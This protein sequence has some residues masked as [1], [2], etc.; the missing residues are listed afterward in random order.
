VKFNDLK[1]SGP[2]K[3]G[4]AILILL[5]C[6]VSFLLQAQEIEIERFEHIDTR[7]GLS[8]NQVL[9]IYCDRSGYLWF[10]TFNGLN[11]Y[12]GYN[13]KI[14]K[15]E[16]GKDHVLT[17]NKINSIW[18]DNRDFLWV[19]TYDGY[20]HY[21]DRS[22]D[23]FYTF[24]RFMDSEEE[25]NS[26]ITCFL[27]YSR[28]EIWLGT[29]NTGIYYL[30]YDSISGI[31]QSRHFVS[32]GVSSI[33][34]NHIR[35]IQTDHTGNIWIGT[36]NG[37]NY[38]SYDEILDEDPQ[39]QH[40]YISNDFTASVV[41]GSRIWHG[42][43]SGDIMIIDPELKRIIGKNPLKNNSAAG[44]ISILHQCSSGH[45]II[46]TGRDGLYTSNS[47]TGFTDHYSLNGKEVRFVFEDYLGNI[48]VVTENF[49][50]NK[51][52]LV[53]G[54]NKYFVLTP[55]DIQPIVDDER[56]YF[57]EDRNNNLWIGLHGGGLAL[58]DRENNQ[59]RFYRNNPNDPK[60]ISSNFVHCIAEDNSGLLWVGTG[61]FNGGI[62]KVIPV[63][64]SFQ[65]IIPAK[66]ID[67]ISE[68][69]IRCVFED[70]NGSIWMATKSGIIY[71]YSSDL[72][73]QAKIDDIPLKSGQI[74]G[75]NIYTITQDK[76][77]YIWMGSKGGGI[78]V[79]SVP[80]DE[81]NGHYKNL[82][83]Y[84]YQHITNDP[85]SLSNDMVYTIL[86]DHHQRIWIGTYGGGLNL[87]EDRSINSLT[88]RRINKENSNLSSNFIRQVYED[89]RGRMWIGSTFG[90][91]YLKD[92]ALQ[93]S[94]MFD[95]FNYEPLDN[96]SISYN[97]VIHLYED[98]RKN[99]WVGTFGGGVNKLISMGSGLASFKSYNENDGLTNDAVFGILEDKD[100]FLWFSTENGI[101]RFNPLTEKMESFNEND[102]LISSKFNENTCYRTHKD[103]LIFGTMNGVLLVNPGKISKQQYLPPVV[104]TNFQLFNRDVDI[105]DINSPLQNTIETTKKLILKHNQ[106]SFSLEYAALHYLDPENNQYAFLLEN[107]DRNWNYVNTQRKATYTNLP[108]GQ[109]IFRV[110]ASDMDGNWKDIST[111]LEIII[112]PPW[113]KTTLAY[114][115]YGLIILIIIEISR[116]IIT[117][118]T[119]LRNDLRV[120]RKVNEIKLQFFTNISH[121]IRTPLTLV[122]GPLEDIRKN[123]IVPEVVKSSVD[124]MYRNGRRMLRLINQL[125]DFRKVQN[126]KMKLNVREVNFP[127][128]VRTVCSN[129]NHLARQKNINYVYNI[130]KSTIHI[131]IDKDM[132]DSVLF[133][134]LS[135]AFKFTPKGK[136][137]EVSM[138]VT[139]DQNFIDVI[140]KDE[141]PGIPDQKKDL[142]FTRYS[143]LNQGD[144][145]LRGTGIG[146][147]LSYELIKMHKGN[148]IVNSIPGKGSEFILRLPLGKEHFEEKDFAGID[149]VRSPNRPR[150]YEIGY[151]SDNVR[152]ADDQFSK[153]HQYTVLVVEDNNEVLNYIADNLSMNYN[154]ICST[155][156][157]DALKSVRAIHPDLIIT[158]IMMPGMN[159][160]E[161]TNIIKSEFEI[162][163]IPII[164]LTAKS[165]IDDQIEGIES[166]AEA[167]I[168]KPFD[169]NYLRAVISNL[170]AQR[171]K[172]L[173]KYRDNFEYE[174]GD[175]KITHRDEEFIRGIIKII[176]K[177][178]S[179]PSFNVEKLAGL[180]NT[181][182][183][184]FYNK[185]KGLTGLTPVEFLRQM[186]LK[187]AAR[188][189]TLSDYNISEIA[190]TCGFND[191][192]Y[193]R[194]CFKSL[195]GKT[196]SEYKIHKN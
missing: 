181:G 50:V 171:S 182:R 38:L 52:D 156:G 112:R 163:H 132:I 192:K 47:R 68:N 69:V 187:I 90:L 72:V 114:V 62:N 154:V 54:S 56:Q 177:N 104:L 76:D 166:G 93:D 105:N 80:L 140:I 148:I 144:G 81:L 22:K 169:S 15:S 6:M 126:N 184:L 27:Q 142:L 110:M 45:I 101:T 34:N 178:Y 4:N 49:G 137:I 66:N 170:L 128:F 73:L 185:I 39:F 160:I 21:L 179:D 85:K 26:I 46:G 168:I 91:H 94:V 123:P 18:E 78:Y 196:P 150:S 97:D 65:Q 106:S 5:V 194:R 189:L 141:G 29:N 25:R 19:K 16:P 162:S 86:Q 131:W 127:D 23:R 43:A 2:K 9:S 79:S 152:S 130:E 145:Y 63:N 147:A 149:Y 153:E 12:D 48:W 190:Y 83:F 11:R 165:T 146:L 129:F 172:I 59:F 89:T 164:I 186:R 193:F 42:T 139:D 116:R 124:I 157:V 134:I 82:Q 33:T 55:E 118:Y 71:I 13:F 74:P 88:C 64:P 60:T 117:R 174:P 188:M 96:N 111:N 167:Y 176:D 158:D 77:G 98:S 1:I 70:S 155:N 109:Y 143:N 133:N 58:F 103:L 180:S 183:T 20:Y 195:Y 138:L 35:Y 108:P 191:E 125:L 120:E 44:E 107:F 121:E 7:H 67:D 87:V 10:G 136:N 115:A 100:G 102:G 24:P 161:M 41:V 28:N 32:R 3:A 173:K 14:Y 159:G 36:A 175:V 53:S 17:Y 122:L 113:W 99:L 40:F 119:R 92:V 61:Q 8:Q 57:Y 84:S 151:E 37:L 31:Y 75:Q 135:N 30:K 95:V 51:I